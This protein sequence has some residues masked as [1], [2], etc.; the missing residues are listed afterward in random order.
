MKV[1]NNGNIK[2]INIDGR[3]IFYLQLYVVVFDVDVDVDVDLPP[4]E[5]M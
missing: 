1:K 3:S 4:F 2:T 5:T